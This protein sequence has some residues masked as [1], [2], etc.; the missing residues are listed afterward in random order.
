MTAGGANGSGGKIL[1]VE[2]L[3]IG[4][5]GEPLMEHLNFTVS[6]GEIFTILGPSGCGK[7]TLLR[8]LIGL[9]P[10]LAGKIR[11]AGEEFGPEMEREALDRLHRSFGVVF[12]EGA[13]VSGLDLKA[14]VALP[15]EEFTSLPRQIIDEIVRLK[16]DMVRL[17]EAIYQAPSDLSGGQLKRAGLARAIANDPLILFCDEPT[18]GL[19]PATATEIDRLL[20]VLRKLMGITIVSISHELASIENYADQ[21]IMLDRH[22]GIIARGTLA[23]LK[24]ADDDRVQSFF[25]RHIDRRQEGLA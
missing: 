10:P 18:S 21:C 23:E 19:D 2:D 7:T 16:L 12:Q 17:S 6:K 8:T 3:A 13:L 4:Y 25:R 22:A 15:L 14:N 20:L 5:G 1:E 24:Q 11:I 9:L